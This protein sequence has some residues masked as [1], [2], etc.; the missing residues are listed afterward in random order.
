MTALEQAREA[1]ISR[2]LA[3]AAIH[4][5]H[6]PHDDEQQQWAD[7]LR[8]AAA[9]LS[10][11]KVPKEVPAGEWVMVP[12]E[13]TQEM[14]ET[15]WMGGHAGEVWERMLTAA[16]AAPKQAEAWMPIETAPK[17]GRRLLVAIE[18]VD[19]AVV[20]FWSGAAWATVDGHDW[21]GRGITHWM[22]LPPA[23]AAPQD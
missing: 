15:F 11:Q 14:R 6:T 17:D 12:R 16:P 22:S 13:P 1:L 3:H 18:G 5:A 4:D 19:R 2:L 20:A 7:D 21:T 9:A 10:A 23:P 8:E